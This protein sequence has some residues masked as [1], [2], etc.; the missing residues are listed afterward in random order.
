[1]S[2]NVQ[3]FQKSITN[4][5]YILKD[6]VRNLIGAA[7]WGEEGRFKEAVVKNVLRKFL[8]RNLSVASGFILKAVGEN[9]NANVLS[10][11]LDII[12]Y[13]NT[14]P[15]LFS[16]GDL[17]ITT[18]T[19]VRGIIEVK[20]RIDQ[21]TISQ[22]LNQFDS[23]IENFEPEI[24]KNYV[25]TGVF[26]FDY[27]GD[28]NTDMVKNALANSKKI[29]R[30]LSLGPTYFVKHWYAEDGERLNPPITTDNNFYN[31]YE[32]QDLSFSYFLNN[33]IDVCCG[34]LDDRY[35]FSFPI[36]GTK[37]QF[38]ISTVHLGA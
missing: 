15:I 5:L 30:H 21:Y 24:S 6:R 13:D 34:G 23:S 12:V 11:Q 37:E 35:W 27:S 25:F 4:E 9:D 7:H 18:I 20:S 8:P 26:S 22:V 2:G 17:I 33:L 14:L 36:E 3:A 31:L 16:E 10:R 38:R 28:I 19:N 32:L 29:V 1:M